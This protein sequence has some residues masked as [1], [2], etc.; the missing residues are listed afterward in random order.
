M[1][2]FRAIGLVVSAALILPAQGPGRRDPFE[3]TTYEPAGSVAISRTVTEYHY[4]LW[5]T[6]NSAGLVGR[7]SRFEVGITRFVHR[8]AL[9]WVWVEEESSRGAGHQLW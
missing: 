9:S 7:L 4:W 5:V 8:S 1:P 2:L 6:N 3:I